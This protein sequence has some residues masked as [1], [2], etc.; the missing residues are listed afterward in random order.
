MHVYTIAS[1]A[2]GSLSLSVEDHFVLLDRLAQHTP[3]RF[4]ICSSPEEITLDLCNVQILAESCGNA[5]IRT[6]ST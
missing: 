4:A 2:I 6:V 1:N 3:R 5:W